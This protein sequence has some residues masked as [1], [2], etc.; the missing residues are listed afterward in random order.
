MPG[1][2]RPL[3]AA[4]R[5]A[6]ATRPVPDPGAD[7]L[8]AVAQAAGLLDPAGRPGVTGPQVLAAY[9]ASSGEPDPVRICAEVRA[10][11]G[12][13]V[14]PIPHADRTLGWACDDG[15][16]LPAPGLPVRMPA[17]PQVGVGARALVGLG[18]RVVLVPALAVDRSG[19]RLGQ[20][21]GYYDRLLA[22][23][24]AG[25]DARPALVAVVHDDE[26]LPAG[27]IPRRSHDVPVEA[28]LTE[29]ALVRLGAD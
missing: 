14:L 1:D 29:S 26:V 6:R 21:G 2:K 23:L 4:L 20:G 27:T 13:V 9:L 24:V 16:S 28:A 8:W 19:T 25:T 7:A 11:G 18:V 3:R 5:A 22:E 12:Q 17:G 15:R 10:A